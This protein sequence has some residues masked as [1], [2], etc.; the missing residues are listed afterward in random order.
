MGGAR[1]NVVG[2]RVVVAVEGD[3]GGWEGGGTMTAGVRLAE[4]ACEVTW[5]GSGSSV[6]CRTARGYGQ[7]GGVTMTAGEQAGSVSGA[8]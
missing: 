3:V 6:M 8:V 5:W 2:A 1:T 7:S 4:T